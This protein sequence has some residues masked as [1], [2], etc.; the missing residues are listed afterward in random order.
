[1]PEEKKE[2]RTVIRDW[3][4]EEMNI[5]TLTALVKKEVRTVIREEVV[6][7]LK[8]ALAVVRVDI[9]PHEKRV[10]TAI[11]KEAEERE[12]DK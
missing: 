11:Q 1:M 4:E 2:V 8:L 12:V 6:R 7:V 10:I 9:V 3:N 5:T